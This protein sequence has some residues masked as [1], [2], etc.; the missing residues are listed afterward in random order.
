MV[1]RLRKLAA[2]ERD[3]GALTRWLLGL[4]G[5]LIFYSFLHFA[6]FHFVQR[7]EFNAYKDSNTVVLSQINA[8]LDSLGSSMT[9]DTTRLQDIQKRLD[10]VEKLQ[11]ER[12]ETSVSPD[13]VA[14][15]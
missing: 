10:R 4:I 11:D 7:V 8:K 13:S 9:Q 12:G 3:W 1:E 2:F 5:F 14:G 15:K 6:D